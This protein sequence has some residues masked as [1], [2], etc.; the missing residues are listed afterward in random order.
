MRRLGSS[1]F[2]VSAQGEKQDLVWVEVRG[3]AHYLNCSA[4]HAFLKKAIVAGKHT[5]IID[6]GACSGA[7]STFFGV[8]AGSALKLKKVA[9]HGAFILQRLEGANKEAALHLGLH[10]VLTISQ[11]F[12]DY[13]AQM[14]LQ[15]LE[16][17]IASADLI[18]KAHEDLIVAEP[19][20]ASE[21]QD[22]VTLIREEQ[23]G[24]HPL[25]N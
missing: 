10:H 21:L 2:W 18:A 23:R 5:F 6:L 11:S 24:S 19:E 12:E 13:S 3:R 16:D 22:V 15:P 14:E 20:N 25:Y 8:L 17:E 9:P 1:V 7:D 4:L